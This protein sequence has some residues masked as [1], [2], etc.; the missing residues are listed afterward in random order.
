[1]RIVCDENI[2][3]AAELF[4][5]LGD[6]ETV[7]GRAIDNRVVR[8]ADLLLVRSVTRVDEALLD[9]ARVRFVASATI[10]TDHVDTACLSARGIHFA[11][12]PG[13]NADSVA[14][15]VSTALLWCARRTRFALEGKTI[16]IVGVGNVGS[17][18]VRQAQALGMRCLLTDPPR[19]RVEGDT[20]FVP[21]EELVADADIATFHV[22]LTRTGIDATYH[23]VGT[24]LLEQMKPGVVLLNT[25]RGAVVD[26]SA[27]LANRSRLSAL[28]LDVWE[29]EPSPSLALVAAATVATPHIAGYSLD[30]KLRGTRMIY[31]EACAFL[32]RAPDGAGECEDRRRFDLDLSAGADPVY[33]AVMGAYDLQG[34]DS[35]M[36]AITMAPQSERAAYFDGLRRDYPARYEFQHYRPAGMAEPARA[37]LGALG[38]AC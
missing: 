28:I 1:M 26:T 20:G 34:D 11:Y 17:R 16:G 37:V 15:Y 32:K 12:A 29:G 36:R 4:G 35:R 30:G 2:P 8:D 3:R 19:Q 14:Q 18:V 38:F 24:S 13:S 31:E 27:L 10:G 5:R 33:D 9:G 22:P 7:A 25:S 6:V 23:L 21:L